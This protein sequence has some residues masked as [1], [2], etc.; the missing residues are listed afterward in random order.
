[1]G[2]VSATVYVRYR[3]FTDA[4]GIGLLAVACHKLSFV[5]Y[6]TCP[7]VPH[8]LRCLFS[9]WANTVKLWSN[10]VKLGQ[11]C[12]LQAVAPHLR[13]KSPPPWSTVLQHLQNVRT[14]TTLPCT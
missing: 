9:G 5:F 10:M 7:D 3:M 14:A 1:M 12:A 11:L 4:L 6:E 2:A 13:P 8:V